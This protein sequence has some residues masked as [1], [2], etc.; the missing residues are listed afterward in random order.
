VDE[1]YDLGNGWDEGEQ[2][3]KEE[4]EKWNAGEE[5][6]EENVEEEDKE[7]NSDKENEEEDAE[8]E[9]KEEE[10]DEEQSY[11][12][13]LASCPNHGGIQPKGHKCYDC[14]GMAMSYLCE[15]DLDANNEAKKM[16]LNLKTM[17][18]S[19]GWRKIAVREAN[20]WDMSRM[21]SWEH[22]MSHLCHDWTRNE[23]QYTPHQPVWGWR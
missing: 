14:E 23:A 2:S 6:E 20:H 10:Q 18:H 11:E 13:N 19:R 3:T 4:D 22:H 9:G 16:K 21:V 15:I 5:D 12:R 8:D 17:P 7:E 1:H